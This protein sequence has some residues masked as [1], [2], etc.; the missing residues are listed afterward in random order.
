MMAEIKIKN[1]QNR[2]RFICTILMWCDFHAV[3]M[4]TWISNS[5]KKAGTNF[6]LYSALEKVYFR[7][8]ILERPSIGEYWNISGVPVLPENVIFTF[9]RARWCYSE[10]YDTGTQKWSGIVQ[11]TCTS[12][13]DLK[14]TFSSALNT[15]IKFRAYFVPLLMHFSSFSYWMWQS[16]FKIAKVLQFWPTVRTICAGMDKVNNFIF[17]LFIRRRRRRKCASLTIMFPP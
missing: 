15:G 11:Y 2:A 17:C 13:W 4:K 3:A 5:D 1:H 16:K 12:I 6:D 7:S 14:Y 8:Q 10:A 9:F